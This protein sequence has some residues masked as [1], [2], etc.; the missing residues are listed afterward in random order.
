MDP[1]ILAYHRQQHLLLQ[2]QGWR[3]RQALVNRGVEGLS[4]DDDTDTA[5]AQIV[6]WE[7]DQATMESPKPCLFSLQAAPGTKVVAPRPPHSK[8]ITKEQD[9][10]LSWITLSSLIQLRRQDPTKVEPLW[11]DRYRILSTW[12][13]PHHAHSLYP[14]L[15]PRAALVTS[16]L[17]SPLFT[18]TAQHG[19]ATTV[20]TYI[21]VSL[22]GTAVLALVTVLTLPVWE[23]VVQQWW[24]ASWWWQQW[25]VWGRWVH[26]AFPLKFL[27]VQYLWKYIA[28]CVSTMRT[29]AQTQLVQWECQL[30]EDCIPQT[31]SVPAASSKNELQDDDEDDFQDSFDDDMNDT[32]DDEE[33]EWE[34]L[35]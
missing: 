7:C 12:F 13:D 10:D 26:A 8:W 32:D 28:L 27:I 17:D 9:K 4:D 31:R 18:M 34:D 35:R 16:L 33:D 3:L 29:A 30:W 5:A 1:D 2:S 25:P 21:M 11:H 15:T 20:A 19:L 23:V 6:D 22:V 14:Y 24:T